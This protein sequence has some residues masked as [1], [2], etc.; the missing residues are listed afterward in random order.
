MSLIRKRDELVIK[1]KIKMLVY[2]SAGAGK[3]TLAL[4]APKPLLLDC[5]NGVHRVH[6]AHQTDTLQVETYD[7]VLSVLEKEDLSAYESIVIDTG[8]KLLDLMAD[9]LI[10]R[11]PKLGKANGTLTLQGYGARKAE[12]NAFCK[13]VSS[14]DKHLVFVAHRKTQSENDDKIRYVP[15]FGG[16]NYDD[17]VTELD[18]VGYLELDGRKRIITFDPT[19]R[20]DGKNTCNLP[21]AVELPL[22]VD[23]KG[24]GLSNVFIS[25]SV[26]TPYIERLKH[27]QQI[28]K[29]IS[30]IVKSFGASVSVAKDANEINK[31]LSQL[32]TIK[33]VGTTEIQCK[34]LLH[35]KATS[36]GLKFDKTKK[37]Y[38]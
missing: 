25:D 35:D 31:L 24:E 32:M 5:D 38:A 37:A 9:Y 36:L 34:R 13:L 30:E 17:L 7:Q 15:L 14:L 8:G 27:N 20:N 19:D 28:G 6:Y 12:F 29:K 22:T 1:P 3:T 11:N 23:E 16:S 2:G 26:I 18:L 21:S 33:H 10:S 4:S